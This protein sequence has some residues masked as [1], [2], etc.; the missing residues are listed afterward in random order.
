MYV[1]ENFHERLLKADIIESLLWR[2]EVPTYR[3]I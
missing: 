3:M 1:Q 2:K